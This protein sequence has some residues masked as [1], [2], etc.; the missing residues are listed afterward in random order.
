MTTALKQTDKMGLKTNW[1]TL[2]KDQEKW[3]RWDHQ[4]ISFVFIVKGKSPTKSRGPWDLLE[5]IKEIPGNEVVR[6]REQN[7][8]T[9]E[10]LPLES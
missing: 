3:K 4:A 6:N 2:L 7:P 9:L 8:V 10:K 5:I 1:F